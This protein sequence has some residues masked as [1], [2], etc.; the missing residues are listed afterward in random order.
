MTFLNNLADVAG[1]MILKSD[2]GVGKKMEAYKHGLL[3]KLRC[4][5]K[6]LS[7][8]VTYSSVENG[9]INKCAISLHPSWHI[10]DDL[11][12]PPMEALAECMTYCKGLLSVLSGNSM[13]N[14]L[15]VHCF[16]Y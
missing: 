2:C 7:R 16:L 6:P 12:L 4:R 15:S 9:V 10:S 5:R 14:L 3:E 13:Q 1:H 8:P 11:L